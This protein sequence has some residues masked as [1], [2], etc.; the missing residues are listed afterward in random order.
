MNSNRYKSSF[1]F[2][3][4][5]LADFSVFGPA[6]ILE[7]IVFCAGRYKFNPGIKRQIKFYLINLR[8]REVYFIMIVYEILDILINN[9]TL[10]VAN[11]GVP[12]LMHGS[13]KQEELH[14]RKYT[15]VFAF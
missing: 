8:F 6:P 12:Y 11:K 2:I 1:Q 5:N 4:W 9:S 15:V 10:W 13:Y 14:G 7:T 3:Q